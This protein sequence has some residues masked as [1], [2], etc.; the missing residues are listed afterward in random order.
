MI[1]SPI[2]PLNTSRS[3]H[4]FTADEFGK[5]IE[6]GILADGQLVELVRGEVVE[7]GSDSARYHFSVDEYERM[8][9]SA[10]LTE[11]ARVEL[12]RGEILNKMPTNPPHAST[13]KRISQLLRDLFG[14]KIAIGVQDPIRLPEAEPEPDISVMRFRADYYAEAHPV[15]EDILLIIEV[16]DSSL[17]E[18]R[19]FKG[20]LYAESGIVEYWIVNLGDA[21]LEVH[22]SPQ[23]DGSYAEKQIVR[24]GKQIEITGLPGVVIEVSDMLP[25]VS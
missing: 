17:L 10:I 24:R 19:E 5:M 15:P 7:K 25:P 12:I 9:E 18:D 14:K 6:L 1:R 20:P 23:P 2:L 16:A 22:R 3:R 4:R 8:V 21:C 13:V 11:N